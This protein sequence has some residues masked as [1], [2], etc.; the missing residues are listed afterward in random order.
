MQPKK[1]KD[2][3]N[4]RDLK[5]VSIKKKELEDSLVFLLGNKKIDRTALMRLAEHLQE[6]EPNG[7]YFPISSEVGIQIYDMNELKHR[8]LL[9][10]VKSSDK[11]DSRKVEAEVNRAISKAKSITFVYSDIDIKRK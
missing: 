5:I 10:V 7:V 8:D 6:L 11:M 1:K 2:I 9:V 3:L 4:T